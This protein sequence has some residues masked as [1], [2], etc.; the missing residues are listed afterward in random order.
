MRIRD[1]LVVVIVIAA[2]AAFLA[3][4]PAAPLLPTTTPVASATPFVH[5]CPY[6]ING[7]RLNATPEQVKAV[8]GEPTSTKDG[9]W[10]YDKSDLDLTMSFLYDRIWS[11]QCSKGAVFEKQGQKV[12]LIGQTREQVV[13]LFG[14][15]DM[16][17]KKTIQ[18]RRDLS[19]LTI[20]FRDGKVS[21][22]GLFDDR[23]TME[24]R[25]KP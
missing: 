1:F 21:E 23:S 13:A 5:P 15:P 19:V 10:N 12:S 7:V 4:K 3:R 24:L 8:L 22:M 9:R 11:V 16:D 6:S 20:H 14:K 25:P 17:A 2:L 18:Y